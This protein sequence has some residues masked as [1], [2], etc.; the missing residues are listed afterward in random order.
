[1]ISPVS[2]RLTDATTG[3]PRLTTEELNRRVAICALHGWEYRINDTALR[4]HRIN[5]GHRVVAINNEHGLWALASDAARFAV[6]RTDF[7][8]VVQRALDK[9]ESGEYV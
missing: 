3:V 4:C 6:Y 5:S 9:Y 2:P 7:D 1:M 8:T